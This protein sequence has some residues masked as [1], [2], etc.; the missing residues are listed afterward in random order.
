M[1]KTTPFIFSG[2]K[3]AKEVRRLKKQQKYQKS[4]LERPESAEL[5][6]T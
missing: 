4:Q 5:F 2:K 3:V 1:L 6:D